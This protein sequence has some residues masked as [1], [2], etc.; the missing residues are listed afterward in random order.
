MSFTV[1]QVI[2][3]YIELRDQV[4][5]I[6]AECAQRTTQA[7]QQMK[8]LEAW[9]QEQINTTGVTSFKTPAGTAYQDTVTSCKVAN[10]DTFLDFVRQNDA[11][12]MLTR[13]ASKDAVKEFMKESQEGVPPPGIDWTEIRA[14]KF[15]RSK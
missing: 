8:L 1:E 9:M 7:K 2:E 5:A 12:H 14:V 4:D 3:K 13:G 10:F 11:W 6:E 15:R